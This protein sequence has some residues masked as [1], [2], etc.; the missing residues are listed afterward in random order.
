MALGR[1]DREQIAVIYAS[2]PPAGLIS[3]QDTGERLFL[4]P[5]Y[6][7]PRLLSRK[8]SLPKNSH[9]TVLMIG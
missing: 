5:E 3:R 8:L 1:R 4:L 6:S 2:I 7:Y 9:N